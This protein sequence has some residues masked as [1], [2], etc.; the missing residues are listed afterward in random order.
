MPASNDA[1][2]NSQTTT[3]SEKDIAQLQKA[4]NPPRP[5]TIVTPGIH[6]EAQALSG[7]E[8]SI[9]QKYS[10]VIGDYTTAQTYDSFAS[11]S[12]L[13]INVPEVSEQKATFVYNYFV[14]DERVK[15]DP[16]NKV[17]DL[18]TSRSDELLFQVKNDNIPRFVKIAFKSPKKH[19]I[20]KTK[21]SKSLILNNLDKVMIE[22][23][24][25]N[26]FYTGFELLDTGA[27]KA[28][29]KALR[30]AFFTIQVPKKK[31][32]PAD[33]LD[34]LLD[35]LNE[36]SEEHEKGTLTGQDKKLLKSALRQIQPS[37]GQAGRLTSAPSDVSD[38]VANFANDPIQ[39][40]AFSLQF[41]NSI[42]R[43]VAE[44]ATRI[45]DTVFQ[46]EFFSVKDVS[47]E[48]ERKSIKRHDPYAVGETYNTFTASPIEIKPYRDFQ[49]K[50]GRNKRKEKYKKKLS[51]QPFNEYPNIKI[52]GYM[53]QKFETNE[54]GELI[55]HGV[56]FSD[57]PEGLYIIDKKVRY[58]GVYT[59]KIRS[60]YEIEL[61]S[62]VRYAGDASLTNSSV[63]KVLV[64]SEGMLTTV[65]CTENIPP[66]PPQ[67]LR[68]SFNFREKKP[69]LTWQFPVNPQ[70][71]I[72][73]FQIFKR[74]SLS[75]PFTLIMEYDFDDSVIRSRVPE[76][77]MAGKVKRFK[78]PQITFLD[79]EYQ[80]GDSPIYTIAS[81]D[82]HG[83]SSNYG[84]QMRISYD[85]R[86]NKCKKEFIS[87]PGAPKPYPNLLIEI[88]A[89]ADSIRVSD[90][91]RMKIY[92]DPEYYKVY[93]TIK[94]FKG[95]HMQK[96]LNFLRIDPN[97]D[98]YKIHMINL[99][100]Q[101]DKILNIKLADKSGSP[102]STASRASFSGKNLNFEFGTD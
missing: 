81:V 41:D 39:R 4:M 70:R 44:S 97:K 57:N 87:P 7:I 78:S 69:Y 84:V 25:T 99:D 34:D 31:N 65:S 76:I 32:S 47:Y 38:E 14:A 48:L 30:G 102:R 64:A 12:A 26:Q 55:N 2:R 23:A 42:L 36:E 75:E 59:Y 95:H 66:P 13:K 3:D 71:D 54:S 16:E 74:R 58:G 19:G 9:A 29:Y 22:G 53:I 46:D 67:N 8:N 56:L 28:L 79:E 82:A 6:H 100:L 21:T 1:A 94:N 61:F 11:L 91:E 20:L 50:G 93:K 85:E 62:E 15:F 43:Q 68:A 33:N 5:P 90:Y 80:P 45:P 89:F 86:R 37:S 73:R 24:S 77:A 83:M 17:L 35:K 88:D 63:C 49:E 40:Q 52:V 92:F 18:S 10:E 27:D 72:K 101:K 98:T 96:E 51:Q 60:L